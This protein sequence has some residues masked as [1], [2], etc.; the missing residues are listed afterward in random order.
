MSKFKIGDVVKCINSSGSIVVTE[1]YKYIV[2]GLDWDNTIPMISIIRD[3]G[4][5]GLNYESR[6]ELVKDI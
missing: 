5:E 4:V 1:E 6:F 3:D 2:I